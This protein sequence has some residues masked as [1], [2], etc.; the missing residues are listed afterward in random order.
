MTH[1]GRKY[2]VVSSTPVLPSL[3]N[4][5]RKY[6]M[7]PRSILRHLIGTGTES[8]RT[9]CDPPGRAT[10][11]EMKLQARTEEHPASQV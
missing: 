11:K 5:E 8:R 7:T 3:I 9:L 6:W 4:T 10:D 1:R 2:L